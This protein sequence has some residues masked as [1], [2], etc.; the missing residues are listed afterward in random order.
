[1]VLDNVTKTYMENQIKLFTPIFEEFSEKIRCA[2]HSEVKQDFLHISYFLKCLPWMPSISEIVIFVAF[3]TIIFFIADIAHSNYINNKVINQ[4]RCL[5]KQ[6]T[7]SVTAIDSNGKT[8]YTIKYD[9]NKIATVT[10]EQ[11]GQ[12]TISNTY[13]GIKIFDPQHPNTPQ[14][15]DQPC[16]KQPFAKAAGQIY[17]TGDDQLVKYMTL[18]DT[19]YFTQA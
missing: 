2:Q 1:M 8:L 12:G 10:C 6:P 9:Q 5:R 19:S 13:T 14:H 16:T 17:Y 7:G 4:S 18:S 11:E 15:K 3:I